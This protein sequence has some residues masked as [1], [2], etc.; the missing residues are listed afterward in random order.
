MSAIS[1]GSFLYVEG[2]HP[3]T[4]WWSRLSFIQTSANGRL[5]EGQLGQG[6]FVERLDNPA[7]KNVA[8]PLLPLGIKLRR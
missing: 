3:V 8:T 2:G 5:S 6:R 4:C 7:E 1:P